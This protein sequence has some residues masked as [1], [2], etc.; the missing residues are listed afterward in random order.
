M[1]NKDTLLEALIG[2]VKHAPEG[3]PFTLASGAQ[4]MWYL[5]CRPV[6]F[7]YPQ[8][9]ARVLLEELQVNYNCV[10]GP[11]I[12]AVP[13]AT[14]IGVVASVRTFAVRSEPKDHGADESL[15]IGALREGDETLVVEDV[16]TTGGSLA[17][18]IREVNKAGAGVAAACVLLN[19][20]GEEDI[21]AEGIPVHYLFTP[22]DL[23]VA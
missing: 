17:R 20:S 2:Q 5:D 10:G 9:V 18:A 6:T 3:E 4:S 21:K 16:F 12:G 13:I 11:A 1:S 14:A 8:L 19:R 23:G 22:A 15:I 7:A